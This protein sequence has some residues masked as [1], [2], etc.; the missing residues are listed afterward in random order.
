MIACH[1]AVDEKEKK[2]ALEQWA[3]LMTDV[4]SECGMQVG[5]PLVVP[6]CVSL[7][8]VLLSQGAGKEDTDKKKGAGGGKQTAPAAV[9][10][11]KKGAPPVVEEPAVVRTPAEVEAEANRAADEG[12]ALCVELWARMARCALDLNDLRTAQSAACAA[13][14]MIP[15]SE[16]QR[17]VG[18]V[19]QRCV[20]TSFLIADVPACLMFIRPLGLCS[21]VGSHLQN[22]CGH[23]PWH[24]SSTLKPKIN[25]H[26]TM[27]L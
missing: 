23:W 6:C 12:L 21:G 4:Q 18:W 22:P 5:S 7:R 25:Q 20:T 2:L 9:S 10:P 8:H 11:A 15:A 14:N 1:A 3:K 24:G 19:C 27:F 26:R 16:T 17:D 13:V